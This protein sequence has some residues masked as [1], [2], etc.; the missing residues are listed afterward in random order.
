[1]NR[2]ISRAKGTAKQLFLRTVG[3]TLV[4]SEFKRARARLLGERGTIR[5][6]CRT[7]GIHEVSPLTPEEQ[8]L[9]RSVSLNVHPFDSMYVLGQADHYL[10]VGL[11]AIRCI[12]AV[13]GS[14]N[15]S[16]IGIK[17][18]LDF[19]VGYGR[20][21]RFLKARYSQAR[22]SGAEIDLSA[23]KFCI[24]QFSVEA[25]TAPHDFSLLSTPDKFDLIW[26]GSLITHLNEISAFALL[27]L[28]R[29]HLAENGVCVFSAHGRTSA[30]WIR[31]EKC[32]YG[33]T[34]PERQKML[35]QYE[36][37]GYGFGEYPHVP[38]YGISLASPDRMRELISQLGTCIFFRSTSW[39]HHHDIYGFQ[40]SVNS[41]L[42]G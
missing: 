19:P 17:K 16:N 24:E 9:V 29:D 40:K 31:Q 30:E 10:L 5:V 38:G 39:D 12:E 13:L 32:T 3:P 14:A 27:H 18:I 7:H 22:I 1:M 35:R 25:V 2:V 15:I 42:Q 23:M 34:L 21:L 6:Q 8:E 37:S 41:H 33:L 11:S 26:C 4:A 36:Q 28:F 20:V